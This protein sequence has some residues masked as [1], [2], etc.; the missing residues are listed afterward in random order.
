LAAVL[1]SAESARPAAKS[2]LAA[3]REG[4]LGPAALD[5]LASGDQVVAALLRGIELLGA[6]DDARAIQQLQIALQQAPTF[7]PVR[8][9]LGAALAQANRHRDAAALLQSVG[10][11]VAGPLP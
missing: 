9:Y 7:T 1:G 10:P 6:G 11:D 2:A 3:A 5:A 4:R 8:L